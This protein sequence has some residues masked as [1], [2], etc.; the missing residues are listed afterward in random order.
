MK[1]LK[2]DSNGKLL[3]IDGSLADFSDK[4]ANNYKENRENQRFRGGQE[5]GR[6]ENGRQEYG[7]KQEYSG[8]RENGRQVSGQELQTSSSLLFLQENGVKGKMENIFAKDYWSLHAGD[9]LLPPLKFSNGKTQEDIVKEIVDL[10]EQG[11]KLIFLHGT[12]GT[13]KSAIALNIARALG[14]ASVVVPVKALQKQYEDDY[15]SKKFLTNKTGGKMKIAMITGREN[16][17]S[18]YFPG[19]SCADPLLPENIKITEKNEAKLEEYYEK[20][21][22]IMTKSG[23]DISKLRSI[24]IAPANPYWSPILPADLEL[25]HLG[26]KKMKYKG[27]DGKDYV[28]YHRRPGCSYYDQYISY[29]EAD[30][31]IFNAAKYLAEVTLG[32]KPETDVEIID[33]A[34][35]FLD[36]LFQQEEINLN[37]LENSLKL[38]IPE[39]N[40]AN[41]ILRKI[42]ELVGLEI[43]NKRLLGIDEEKV[44]HIDETKIA[45]ILKL[46][47]SN[48]DLEAE[49]LLDEMNY[50]NSVLESAR[51][52]KDSL[53]EVYLTFRKDEDNNY[54]AKLASTNLSAKLNELMDKSKSIVFMS[55]TLHSKEVL[56][57][58]FKMKEYKVV[59]AETGAFG[60][61]EIV[62]TGKEFNCS[63]A[64]LSARE[65]SRNDYLKSFNA[66]ILKADT[67]TLIH[68]N[69]YNDLP[70]ENEIEN[71]GLFNLI[72]SEKLRASQQE[73]K[74]GNAVSF[75]KKG[76]SKRLFTTKCSR[77]VD[78]PGDTCRSIV[79]TKYPNAN[80]S[81]TF[82]KILKKTQPEN[83][84][85][86]YRDKARREFIQRIYRAL[87]SPEDHVKILS[88]DMR[89]LDA[90]RE[91]QEQML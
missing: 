14:S 59:E 89:V 40:E 1:R 21:P 67:P 58:L 5:Y 27:C 28:F 83:Y 84:W 24:S 74:E 82:W 62:R 87:R 70:N 31:I 46:I 15:M 85:D 54:L 34:D 3:G 37:R 86:F 10:V 71:L 79:F 38:I 52:F 32:R 63:Y 73:D 2:F 11:N 76:V 47:I 22:Q 41:D 55:G 7:G 18:V 8:S 6:R 90:V 9:A 35:D 75:F 56:K 13:G 25:K 36:S 80:V 44:F 77:G 26:G 61:L 30:V 91:L 72:S 42:I 12:C 20:N 33:E 48:P 68:V 78:F 43:K 50:A 60:S 19:K 45:N 23:M 49:I 57:N 53:E 88:P 17:D 39:K 4:S 64:S 65:N 29:L 51:N 69:A 81:D 16:H 66:C